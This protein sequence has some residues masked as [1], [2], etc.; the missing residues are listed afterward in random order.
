MLL[1]L[2][3]SA[4]VFFWTV[5]FAPG[6]TSDNLWVEEEL[7]LPP[8]PDLGERW[9][10]CRALFEGV[11]GFGGEVRA[12]LPDLSIQLDRQNTKGEGVGADEELGVA[13]GHH[14][15]S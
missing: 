2:L 1:A 12:A 13:A 10:F 11:G 5:T 14:T 15:F 8:P 4:V 3:V 6:T 7:A 9:R